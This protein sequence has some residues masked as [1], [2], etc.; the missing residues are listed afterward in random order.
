MKHQVSRGASGT[1]YSTEASGS[2]R[3][4]RRERRWRK[5]GQTPGMPSCSFQESEALRRVGRSVR[6]S[7]GA[8]TRGVLKAVACPREGVAAGSGTA[9]ETARS[10]VCARQ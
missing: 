4:H 6:S 10:C 9:L 5:S 8:A 3:G 7:E 2:C 1:D